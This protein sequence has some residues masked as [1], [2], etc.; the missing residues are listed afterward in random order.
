[1]EMPDWHASKLARIEKMYDSLQPVGN[2]RV[3]DG[4]S[5]A[6][7]PGMRDV[8]SVLWQFR[9]K[10][11]PAERN[12]W[13]VTTLDMQAAP[14]GAPAMVFRALTPGGMSGRA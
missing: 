7:D 4:G 5:P 1:M 8:L 11:V 14:P 13:P 3:R 12:R 2:F 6:P 10:P 9:N